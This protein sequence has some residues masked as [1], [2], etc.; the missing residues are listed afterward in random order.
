MLRGCLAR[1]V[2]EATGTQPAIEA[3]AP[4]WIRHGAEAILDIR[5]LDLDVW[6][7]VTVAYP[8]TPSSLAS[9]GA[10][11]RNAEEM[12]RRRYPGPRLVP[13][14]LESHGRMGDCFDAFLRS[15]FKHLDREERSEAIMDARQRISAA[16]WKGNAL[17]IATAARP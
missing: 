11:S 17:L 16:L 5:L 14:A 3:A 12:K 4:H 1:I 2:A 6:L 15:L 10:P 13:C 8:A 7:D 9:D